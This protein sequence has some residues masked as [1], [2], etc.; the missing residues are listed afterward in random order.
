MEFRVLGAIEVV[1]DDGHRRPVRGRQLALLAFLLANRNRPLSTDRILDALW[2]DEPPETGAKTVAFHVSRLRDAL[3]PGRPHDGTVG[4]NNAARAATESG[5]GTPSAAGHLGTGRAEALTTVAGGYLLRVADAELDAARFEQLAAEGGALRTNDPSTAHE[6]LADALA[7]WRGDRPYADL[8][9]EASLQPEIAHLEELRLRAHEDLADAD[10]ALGRHREVAACLADLVAAEPL[11]ERLRGQLVVA[12]YRSGRQADALR[13]LAEGRAVLGSELGLDP[14]PELRR[15]EAWV[16]AQDPRLDGP[17]IGRRARN[18][19]KGLRAFGEADEGDFFGRET[20]VERLIDRLGQRSRGGRLLV[21][22]G[23]SGSGK[24]SAVRAGLVPAVRRGA[25]PGSER[26]PVALMLPGMHPFRELASALSA[27]LPEV[28]AKAFARLRTGAEAVVPTADGATPPD[29]VATLAR[30]LAMATPPELPVLLVIDQAE[31][32]FT[33]VDDATRGRFLAQLLDAL[34]RPDSRLL[35]VATLRADALDLALRAPSLGELVRTGLE[36]VTPLD[37]EGQERAITRPAEGVG[38]SLEPG[39]ASEIIADLERQPGE[40]PLL[41]FAL[42]ELFARSDGT[43]LTRADYAATGGVLGALAR[44]ADEALS[45]LDGPERELARQVVLRLVAVGPTGEPTPRRVPRRELEGVAPDRDRLVAVLDAFVTRRLLS[46]DRDS[47]TGEG[48]VEVAHAALLVRWPRL[49]GWVDEARD[50]LSML[51]RLEES[52]AEWMESGREAGFLLTG[53]RLERLASWAATTGLGLDPNGR[54]LVEASLEEQRLRTAADVARTTRERSLE[55]RATSRL[56]AMVGV[57][58]AAVL[59]TSTLALALFGQGE[60][61]REQ[62]AIA[63]ARERAAASIGNL[64]RDPRL[65]LLLAWYAADA[66][67]DR[68]YVVVEALD[69]LH[70]ALQASHVAYPSA[71][72]AVAVRHGPAGDRGAPL[73]AP[74]TV[75]GIAAAQPGRPLTNEECRT[76]LHAATCPGAPVPPS[77]PGGATLRVYAGGSVVPVG[78]LGGTSLAGTQVEVLSQLPGGMVKQLAALGIGDGIDVRVAADSGD[79]LDQRI[80]TGD[81]PDVA[82]VARPFDVA[83]MARAGQLVDLSGIVDESTL[84]A[85]GGGDLLAPDTIAPNGSWPAASGRLV[86]AP[87]AVE[88]ESLVWYPRAAFEAAGYRVPTTWDELMTLTAR[89]VFDGH[90]PWCLGTAGGP[91]EGLSGVGFVED[92]VLASSVGY[93]DLWVVG[94]VGFATPTIRDGF[95]RLAAIVFKSGSLYGGPPSA[96]RTPQ[97]TAVWPLSDTPPGCWLHLGGGSERLG[98]HAGQA[99]TLAAFPVPASDPEHAGV[100]RGRLYSVV[101]FHDRPEVRRM[102]A[103]LLDMTGA[104]PASAGGLVGTLTGAGLWPIGADAAALPEAGAIRAA[105]QHQRFRVSAT[106][107]VP[108]VASA[109]FGHA[110]AQLVASDPGDTDGREMRLGSLIAEVEACWPAWTGP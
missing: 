41:Q 4:P 65:A 11:R 33:L 52:T 37:R 59:V 101:V 102:L 62:Q 58:L 73:L 91:V 61:A 43:R 70:W 84:R 57:L 9:D 95:E 106:D 17:S 67:V 76:Y 98:W 10:L 51:R 80:A 100:L 63:V 36:L 68:G 60:S 85:E 48:T 30:T 49:A 29:G 77:L 50:D 47:T 86:G 2:G 64:G 108:R 27:A 22:A 26:W 81:L 109:T 31:E 24:S 87:L 71:T 15:L 42:T 6:R 74:E 83:A 66:T 13:T 75:M 7:L 40:L 12:L 72:E 53:M 103:G 93:Y 46:F 94:R 18:P 89:M 32:L 55:R 92:S 107:L 1:G 104:A 99:G 79:L 78:Q 20:L 16:L 96:A 105:L 25:L 28:P 45:A 5:A 3:A 97:D 19:Y 54:A 23:P 21:V 90:T 82:I 14:G 69:A 56:R 110:V 39:L 34:E 38:A 35:V 88:A 44:R 8:A